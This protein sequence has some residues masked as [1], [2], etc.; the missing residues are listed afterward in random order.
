MNKKMVISALLG[1]G[2]GVI[3]CLGTILN[4][5]AYS[6]SSRTISIVEIRNEVDRL[7][8]NNPNLAYSSNPY[9]YVQNNEIYHN[10]VKV[11]YKFLPEIERTIVD[12]NSFGLEKYL[13]AIAA[14]EI[15]GIQLKKGKYRWSDPEEFVRAWNFHLQEVEQRVDDIIKSDDNLKTKSENL[16]K[17]GAPAL[18]F[19]VDKINQGNTEVALAIDNIVSSVHQSFSTIENHNID[20][21]AKENEAQLTFYRSL[22]KN[23]SDKT[24]IRR[25]F[26]FTPDT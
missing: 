12:G 14:E 25:D 15:A 9:D 21:W 13:L 10:I 18:P 1:I 24:I 26:R 20:R 22:V 16:S 7:I 6:S 11:G 4:D 23:A 17:L 2:I 5:K 19:L 3:G 8:K